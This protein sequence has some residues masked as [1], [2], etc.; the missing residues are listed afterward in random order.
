MLQFSREWN[1]LA[2][3]LTL[4]LPVIPGRALSED[5]LGLAPRV[6]PKESSVTNHSSFMSTDCLTNLTRRDVFTDRMLD[7]SHEDG[8]SLLSFNLDRLKT[9][10]ETFSHVIGDCVLRLFADRLTRALRPSDIA[11]R[12]G[13]DEFLA[14]LPGCGAQ[15]ALAVARQVRAGFQD[16][17]RLVNG[18]LVGATV[19]V[20]VATIETH[21]T[22][23]AMVMRKANDALSR[24]KALGGDGIA[25]ADD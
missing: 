22:G 7:Q 12:M 9:V 21:V 24:A 6:K 19:S 1:I 13:G 2:S 25:V 5:L 17:A 20:G 18:Q 3:Q 15:A 14:V 10:N 16:D 23:L 11:A 4:S 8:V